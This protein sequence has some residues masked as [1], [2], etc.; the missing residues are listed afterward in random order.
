MKKSKSTDLDNLPL[1][2][3]DDDEN[4]DDELFDCAKESTQVGKPGKPKQHLK[5]RIIRSVWFNVKS[6][7]EKH[8]RELIMLFT[9]WRNEETD[10]MGNSSS[11]QEY[12][13]L[14]KEQ[15]DKQ[16]MQYA[17]CSE[18]LNEIEQDLHNTD[19]NDEQ[20][21]PIA[22]NT[23]NVELQDEAEGT[24]DLHPDFSENYDL[25]DD[26]GIPSTS[27]NSEPLI[28]NELPDCD[29][30]QMIQTLNKEQKEFFLSHFTSD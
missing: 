14:L 18:D 22:P 25:S 3:I 11:Y 7:S 28:L 30:R 4:N 13:L 20:F 8:Y 27:L 16:M 15:I 6:Q 1:E 9:S 2:T 10:L 24:E 23:Q 19:Y 17:V 26:L 21:D 29:F 12:Y 5:P